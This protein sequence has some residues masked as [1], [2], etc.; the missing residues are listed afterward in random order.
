MEKIRLLFEGLRLDDIKV[1]MGVIHVT[2]QH[3]SCT[4]RNQLRMVRREKRLDSTVPATYIDYY[5][6]LLVLE[7]VSHH[8]LSLTG[9]VLAPDMNQFDQCILLGG[10][11]PILLSSIIREALVLVGNPRPQ[12]TG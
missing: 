10:G 5:I 7:A 4:G 2:L 6:V 3:P 11:T 8:F 12:V 9:V 1:M